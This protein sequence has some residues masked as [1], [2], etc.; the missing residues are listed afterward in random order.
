MKRT[1]LFL[2]VVIPLI[3][4]GVADLIRIR[5]RIHVKDE[6]YIEYLEMHS[7][8]SL[9]NGAQGFVGNVS[10][11]YWNNDSLVVSGK[12]GCFLIEFGKTKYN[13]EM[14]KITCNQINKYIS[15]KPIK[16]YKR[17]KY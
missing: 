13:D 8:I 10:E 15:K 6:F 7:S 17:K 11:A 9:W 1:I 5:D 12:N 16:K 2:F 3:Y 14:I 4:Y